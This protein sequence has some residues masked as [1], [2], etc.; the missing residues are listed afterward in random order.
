MIR[1]IV[2]MVPNC[3]TLLNLLSGCVAIIFAFHPM[4]V[5][6]RLQGWE[7]SAIM[8]GAA[9]LFDFLDGAVAR[10]LNAKS[11]IGKELDSLS[12]LVSFGVAPGLLL[13]NVLL[14]AGAGWCSYIALFIPLMGALR[15]AKFNVDDSQTVTFKGLPI[16]ANA[17]FWIGVVGAMMQGHLNPTLGITVAVIVLVGLL[18][19]SNLPMFSL[20]MSDFSFR[21]N[22]VRYVV[23]AAAVIF[24]ATLGVAGFAATILLYIVVSVLQR[25]VTVTTD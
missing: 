23:I 13:M 16:P 1:N 21:N 19:V 24:V 10:L 14:L 18:M 9:A 8:M 7:W 2:S 15:L 5:T 11:S 17:I 4:D 20:K 22:I 12:D 6:D 25:I 3:I